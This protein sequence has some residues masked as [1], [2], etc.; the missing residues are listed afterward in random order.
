M[1]ISLMIFICEAKTK[2]IIHLA[3]CKKKKTISA[4]I[5]SE[6]WIPP[7]NWTGPNAALY[8]SFDNPEGFIM[9]EGTQRVWSVPLV[10]GK[11]IG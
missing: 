2:F 4:G 6:T 5:S 10:N 7:T 3:F 1:I 9:M 11:V 8:W